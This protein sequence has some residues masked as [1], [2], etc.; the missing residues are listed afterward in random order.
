MGLFRISPL[1]YPR[2]I[3]ATGQIA[4]VPSKV[5]GWVQLIGLHKW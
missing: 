1:D 5:M 4:G 3:E 2:T